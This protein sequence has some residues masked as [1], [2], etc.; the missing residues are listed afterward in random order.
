MITLKFTIYQGSSNQFLVKATL[1]G[2]TLTLNQIHINV[3]F[4]KFYWNICILETI[5]RQLHHW[6]YL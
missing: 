1:Y 6:T 3:Y 2:M 5:K 4:R